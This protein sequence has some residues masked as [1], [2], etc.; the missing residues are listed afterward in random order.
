[1]QRIETSLTSCADKTLF[2]DTQ[3]RAANGNFLKVPLLGGTVAN[4]DDIFV[5]VQEL[6]TTGIS[7]PVITELISDIETA[8]SEFLN[9]SSASC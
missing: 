9:V 5:V 6:V 7:V 3:Q 8:V 2:A 4:E 1:M